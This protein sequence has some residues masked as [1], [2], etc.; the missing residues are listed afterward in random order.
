M[1]DYQTRNPATGEPIESYD[2]F[3]RDTVRAKLE[4]AE[5]AFGPWSGRP[6]EDRAEI[7]FNTAGLLREREERYADLMATEMGKPFD[8]GISEIEKCAW[9]C[10]YYAKHAREFLA[11]APMESDGSKAFLAY[12]PLGPVLAVMP[13][14]FPFWQVFRFAAPALMAGNIGLLK[15]SKITTGCA[16]EIETLL[17]DAGCPEGVFTTLLLD[18][19]TAEMVI[20]DPVVRAVTLT[21]STGAGK[22]IASI[23]GG[24]LKK[25]VLELGG[26]DPYV[27]LDDADPEKAAEICVSGRMINNGESCIAAKRFITLPG[28]HDRFVEC[29]VEKMKAY[30]MG[31]PRESGAKLGPMASESLRDD[32]HGQVRKSVDAGAERLLGGEVPEREGFWYPATVL[33][34]VTPDM[35]AGSEELFGPVACVLASENEEHAIELANSTVFGLGAAVITDHV[36]RGEMIAREHLDAGCCF[37]NAF[38]K[39]DPRLPFGG[40]KQSGY[41]RE[42]SCPGIREFVNLKTVYVA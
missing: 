5:N 13:W 11:D 7:L 35:P 6:F 18:H 19:D 24:A 22:K 36:Q 17:R 34:G 40:V 31:D 12:R 27:V 25:T 37:V 33:T 26:S 28:I 23:A 3:S 39:S 20:E 42:L 30:P 15:H 2:N 16:L 38:V 8:S 41:G 29:V 32:L 1:S 21:G 9:V 14:N 10:E 4:A